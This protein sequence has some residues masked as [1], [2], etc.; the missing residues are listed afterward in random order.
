MRV[1]WWR[2]PI[3]RHSRTRSL[4]ADVE[5]ASSHHQWDFNDI[6]SLCY[7]IHPLGYLSFVAWDVD[8][9]P[10]EYSMS[11][12]DFDMGNGSFSISGLFKSKR[13]L[14]S[15]WAIQL[16]I[17]GLSGHVFQFTESSVYDAQPNSKTKV[18]EQQWKIR[19]SS[20]TFFRLW[21]MEIMTDR[22]FSRLT[23]AF[24]T[25]TIAFTRGDLHA[26]EFIES[27]VA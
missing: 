7:L 21:T 3:Y 1:V 6:E 20:W 22:S 16:N 5:S 8:Y 18:H 14:A 4:P 12:F 2:G 23:P 27:L 25:P 26:T 19:F 9:G 13:I 24:A 17:H 10:P 15:T 11:E